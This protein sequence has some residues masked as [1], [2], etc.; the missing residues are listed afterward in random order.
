MPGLLPA[1]L[2]LRCSSCV[3][4]PGSSALL[5]AARCGC[6]NLPYAAPPPLL[7][8]AFHVIAPALTQQFAAAAFN[9]LVSYHHLL[10]KPVSSDALPSA[11]ARRAAAFTPFREVALQSQRSR[12]VGSHPS[13][14]HAAQVL[15]V[16]HCAGQNRGFVTVCKSTGYKRAA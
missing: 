9:G 1:R 12:A 11:R 3:A 7:V 2:G 15:Q 16:S 10:Q 14:A 6:S 4:T 13:A 8:S 5:Q